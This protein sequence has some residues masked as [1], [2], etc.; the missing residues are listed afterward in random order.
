M[1]MRVSSELAG[2]E[3]VGTASTYYDD[4]SDPRFELALENAERWRDKGL[5]YVI[6]DGS[7]TGVDRNTWVQAA[8][9]Q[10]GAI[11]IQAV[12]K[13]V[14]A[15]RQQG[16]G[17]SFA[18]GAEKVIGHD[19]EKVL[20]TTFAKEI[21]DSLDAHQILVIGRTAAA[22]NSLPP[23]QAW[24]EDMAGWIL[25][26]THDFPA[27]AFSG[28]RG[29]TAQG[30]Q[31]LAD[32]PATDPAFNNWIYLYRTPLEARAKGLS[33]GGLSVDLMHPATMTEQ[34]T[35]DPVFDRKRFDQFKVQLD[36]MMARSDVDSYARP[37]ADAV[38][39]ALNGLT[40]NHSNEVFKLQLRR[41]EHR[42]VAFGYHPA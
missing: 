18:H 11:V 5:P 17:Y 25:E 14:G 39:H 12:V 31:V 34:E 35:D 22:Q 16:V 3:L 24:T 27:D 41:L 2:S 30:G 23:V 13:G 4:P 10:R 8:H 28:G 29:F 9:E 36:Y 42:L 37:I 1:N 15:Q 6:V 33:V 32:Y 19:P 21:S 38:L 26:K 20:M 40:T 7:S